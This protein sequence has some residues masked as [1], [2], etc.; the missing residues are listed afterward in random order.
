MG[1][2][3]AEVLAEQLGGDVNP[4]DLMALPKYTAYLRLLI[5]G[6]PSRPFS[7]QTLPLPRMNTLRNRS[8]VIRRVSRR[9]YARPATEV[10]AEIQKAFA[11]LA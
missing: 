7:V 4:H 3:D 10:G 6:M 11:Y 5:D 9:R 8:D 1:Q 2:R